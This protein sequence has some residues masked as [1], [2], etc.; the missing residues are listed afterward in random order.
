[1]FIHLN[2]SKRKRHQVRNGACRDIMT[3][4]K[5][6]EGD[7]VN[8]NTYRVM[9]MMEM[10][11]FWFQWYVHVQLVQGVKLLPQQGTRVQV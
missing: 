8:D 1:M 3:E 5:P 11:M 4:Q 6:K 2:S 9:S 10:M 7:N